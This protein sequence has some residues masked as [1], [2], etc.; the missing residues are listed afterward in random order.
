[1]LKIKRIVENPEQVDAIMLRY[2]YK[3]NPKLFGW[4]EINNQCCMFREEMIVELL[5]LKD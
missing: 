4:V 5:K 1:M 2:G 3:Y